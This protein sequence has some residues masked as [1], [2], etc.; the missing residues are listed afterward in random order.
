MTDT[1]FTSQT[2][3]TASAD[4]ATAYTLCTLFSPDADGTVTHGR[5]RIATTPPASLIAALFE[6]TTDVG[7]TLLA[8]KA[9]DPAA[10]AAAAGT[11]LQVAYDTPVAVTAGKNY[12]A[13]YWT[14]NKYVATG[15]FFA[16][17]SVVSGH[18]TA[19]AD[20]TV[21]PK[22]NGRFFVGGTSP[23]YP[24][25]QSGGGS[26]F[27]DVVYAPAVAAAVSG[28]LAGTLPSLTG[29]LAGNGIPSGPLAGIL[30]AFTGQLAGAVTAPATSQANGGWYGL[31][32][33]LQ[34]ASEFRR[35]DVER[36]RLACPNDGE[37][38][39]AGPHGGLFCPFDGWRPTS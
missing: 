6:R 28:A 2:P 3:S 25:N 1:I 18:L 36:S 30:P 16:G 17:A 9:A 27:A 15:G 33:V 12:Y 35:A 29:S 13:A 37:P 5:V 19:P 22:R 39:R 26:Y 7:G 23:T 31:L 10:L 38:L 11:W 14:P 24:N 20:D 34:E 4:D 32:S 8:T 21:T